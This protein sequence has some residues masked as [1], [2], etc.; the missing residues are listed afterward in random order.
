MFSFGL[1]AK[2][3]LTRRTA[4]PLL[5]W[6]RKIYNHRAV[7]EVVCTS[8]GIEKM[9]RPKLKNP[10]KISMIPC[11]VDLACFDQTSASG[12]IRL[13]YSV[14]KQEK[15]IVNIASLQPNKDQQ[16]FVRMAYQLKVLGLPARYFII[17]QGEMEQ[18]LRDLIEELSMQDQIYLLGFRTD[19]DELL[20]E[21]DLLVLTSV[22]EGVATA[23]MEAMAANV[24]V[25]GSAVSG[26]VEIIIDGENGLLASPMRAEEF[27]HQAHALLTD[28]YLYQKIVKNA[29]A[30][31]A[32]FSV[33]QTMQRYAEI[34]KKIL[35]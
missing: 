2:L 11:G 20:H 16:T 22:S 23:A 27:A 31:V 25:L 24:P 15:V 26:I 5:P 3:I 6:E 33:D 8:R 29:H 30:Y 12:K 35:I 34:Y 14:D 7:A 21:A 18:S 19:T 32:N 13:K 9:I 17:G 28:D 4:D 10:E 1:N